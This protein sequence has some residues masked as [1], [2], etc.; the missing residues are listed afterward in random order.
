MMTHPTISNIIYR[1]MVCEVK[2]LPSY[3]AQNDFYAI[4]DLIV[5]SSGSSII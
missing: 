2:A 4:I 1:V 3:S 5:T